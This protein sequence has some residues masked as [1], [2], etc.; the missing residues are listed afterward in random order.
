MARV[1]QDPGGSCVRSAW[2]GAL[3]ADMQQVVARTYARTPLE[4]A[5]IHAVSANAWPNSDELNQRSQ[6]IPGVDKRRADAVPLPKQVM[7][8][9]QERPRF[10]HTCE[11]TPASGLSK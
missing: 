7:H 4:R 2:R 9:K 6:I 3:T 10:C 11:K 1:Q 8:G 5:Q